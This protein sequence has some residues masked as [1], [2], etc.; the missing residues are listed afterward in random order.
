MQKVLPT[1]MFSVAMCCTRQ[2]GKQ[3]RDYPGEKVDGTNWNVVPEESAEI[4]RR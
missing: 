2:G 4:L 3:L 1:M